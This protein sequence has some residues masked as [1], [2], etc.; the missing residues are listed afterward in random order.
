MT[1]ILDRVLILGAK[2]QL[3][4][5]LMETFADVRP[6]AI[7]RK[8]VDV[9]DGDALNVMMKTHRPTLVINATA[10]HQVDQCELH[11]ERAFAVNAFAV[12]RLAALCSIAGS[13][14]LTVSSDYVFDG[15]LGRAYREDDARAPLNAYGASKAA[16]EMLVPRHGPRYFIVRTSGLFG[17]LQ[18]SVKG[19]TFIERMLQMAEGG[20]PIRVVDDI[21]FSPSYTPHVA[22]GIRAMV[23]SERFGVYHVT[24][25]GACSWY[26]FAAEAFRRAGLNPDF[27]PSK[28]D[29][30]AGYVRR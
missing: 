18:S 16:G 21:V 10:Y 14:F 11:P 12:D 13:A 24:N 29:P 8:F 3:G 5:D 30:S 7:D 27:A 1:S 4:A 2:G 20:K 15:A 23:E 6:V 26:D 19:L 28:T 9:E 17:H 22:R 25:S